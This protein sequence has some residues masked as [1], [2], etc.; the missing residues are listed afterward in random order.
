MF[1]N[2]SNHPSANWNNAQCSAAREYGE[3][4]DIPFPCMDPEMDEQQIHGLVEAKLR[5]IEELKPNAIFCAGE[6]TVTYQLVNALLK[7]GYLVLAT[8]SKRVTSEEFHDDGTSTKTS[9]YNFV[10]FRG[11]ANYE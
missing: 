7:R 2:C 10:R 5:E 9:R 11:Y 8:C 6:Y 3:I 4:L 1:I